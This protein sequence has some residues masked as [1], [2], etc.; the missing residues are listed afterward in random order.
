MRFIDREEVAHRLTYDICI[1]L[2]SA[3]EPPAT[4]R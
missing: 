2:V 4:T 1:P 3:I